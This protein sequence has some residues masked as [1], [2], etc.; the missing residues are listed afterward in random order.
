MKRQVRALGRVLTPF[1]RSWHK[2]SEM[3]GSAQRNRVRGSCAMGVW[4]VR[5]DEERQRWDYVPLVSV[6]PLRFGMGYQEIIDALD[7]FVQ[8]GGVGSGDRPVARRYPQLGVT[9]YYDGDIR[10]AGVAVDTLIG[11]QVILD[12]TAL[13][14]Q[15]PSTMEKW[16][17]EYA[18]AQGYEVSYIHE[19]NPAAPDLGLILRVQRAGDVVLTRPLFLLRERGEWAREPWYCVHAYEW[20]IH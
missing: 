14:A 8:T 4:N 17:H 19:G 20:A 10:L 1:R 2:T 5:N 12:G 6:G 3:V 7:P 15:V 18:K 13:V 9:V 11:P 16:I